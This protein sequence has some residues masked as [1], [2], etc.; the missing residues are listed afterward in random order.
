MNVNVI[1]TNWLIAHW[2]ASCVLLA[3]HM[4]SVCFAQD[5]PTLLLL[6]ALSRLEYLDGHYRPARSVNLKQDL[7]LSVIRSPF[8]EKWS[9]PVR[10]HFTLLQAQERRVPRRDY[11]THDSRNL[12]TSS[13]TT[14]R[15]ASPVTQGP[16]RVLSH[17]TRRWTPLLCLL[18]LLIKC[19]WELQQVLLYQFYLFIAFL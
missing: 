6:T 10:F 16:I 14:K 1:S 15:S 2:W 7:V 4:S 11:R 13:Q 19:I 3:I 12:Q 18:S 8:F 5:W 17:L 9:Q